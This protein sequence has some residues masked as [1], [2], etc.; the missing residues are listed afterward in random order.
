MRLILSLV[1]NPPV[2]ISELLEPTT[3]TWNEQLVRSVFLPNDAEEILRIP[4]CTQNIDDFWAWQLDSKGI[5]TVR[6]AYKVII[7]TKIQREGWLD[8]NGECSDGAKEES[9]WSYL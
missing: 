7:K 3:A 8:G 2:R 6:S 5:F 4:V 9:A 1:Q